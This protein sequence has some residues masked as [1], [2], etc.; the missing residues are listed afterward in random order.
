M[1]SVSFRVWTRVAVSIFYD[2]NH[3]TMGT[4][5]YKEEDTLVGYLFPPPPQK[6]KSLS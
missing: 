3:Y 6:K 5:T 1:Q 2:D 4:S